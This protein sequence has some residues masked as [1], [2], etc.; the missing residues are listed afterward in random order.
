MA[1]YEL[2]VGRWAIDRLLSAAQASGLAAIYPVALSP[3]ADRWV[4]G[5]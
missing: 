1:R 5:Y 3:P 4:S 2:A